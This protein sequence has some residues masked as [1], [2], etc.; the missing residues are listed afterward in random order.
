MILAHL[1][2]VALAASSVG[3]A[4]PIKPPV[5][6]HDAVVQPADPK[7]VQSVRLSLVLQNR[8]GLDSLLAQQ[9]DPNSP[10]FR[11]W[12][13]PTEIGERFGVPKATYSA[14]VKLLTDSGLRVKTFPNRIYIEAEG[15]VAKVN[16]LLG[17]NSVEVTV[18]SQHF[19]SFRGTP[20]LPEAFAALVQAVGGLDNRIRAKHRLSAQG[21]N[22]FGPQDLRRFYD[23]DALHAL[24]FG[25]QLSKV[26]M[27]GSVPDVNN[28]VNPAEINYFYQ[29]VSDSTATLVVD[30]LPLGS[31]Q[32]DSQPGLNIEEA[33]DA[34]MPTVAAP[35]VQ[36]V[37]MVLAPPDTLFTSGINEINNNMPDTTSVSISFGTCEAIEK[38]PNYT[39]NIGEIAAV[40]NL[41]AEGAAEG[42][43]YFSASG[44]YGVLTCLPDAQFAQ[45]DPTLLG[46]ANSPSV[47]FPSGVPY[48]TAVGGTMY[49]GTFDANNAIAAYGNETTW[50]EGNQAAGGGGVSVIFNKPPWQYGVPGTAV[51]GGMREV[52]DMAL[53]AD[54]SPGVAIVAT[55]VGQIDPQGNGTSDAA[56]MAA[57]MFAL[58]NDVIGGCRFG[59]VNPNL[60]ALAAAQYHGGASVLHDITTG[61]ISELNSTQQVVPGPM[62]QVGYDEATGVG[63]LDVT[64]LAQAWPS[65]LVGT[66][67]GGGITTFDGGYV[68]DGGVVAWDGG[69]GLDAG[70]RVPYDPCAL[71]TCDADAGATCV[72]VTE[73]PASCQIPCNPSVAN[74]C[75]AGN[76]CAGTGTNGTCQVGCGVTSDCTNNQVCDGCTHA[77]VAA[78]N[79]GA[80]IGDACNADTDCQTGGM[81][82]P[83]IYGLPGGYCSAQCSSSAVCSCPSGA[84]CLSLGGFAFCAEDCSVNGQD[85]RREASGYV[86]QPIDPTD[87]G[88]CFPACNNDQACFFD[89]VR[90]HCDP[91]LHYCVA[92]STTTSTSTSTGTTTS[93]TSTSTTSTSNSTGTSGT[94]STTSTNGTG[95]N[96]SPTA[97]TGSAGTNGT[98][99]PSTSTS[100]GSV[101]STS[102]SSGTSTGTTASPTTGSA[103]G[104]TGSTGTTNPKKGCGCGTGAGF[105]VNGALLLVLAAWT[106]RR[107]RLV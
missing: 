71:I 61:N 100:T 68:W 48:M 75:G 59:G 27:I 81:C 44:D 7:S 66:P 37:T 23:I 24:G 70:A 39:A 105:E 6:P 29:A 35:L 106:S 8:N 101:N 78:G 52:P 95:T 62:A 10:M 89:P 22:T 60:Y 2:S 74:T 58:I 41:V 49:T 50:N 91:T 15:T 57:G 73:G 14:M 30:Q 4:L 69:F 26:A 40:E 46:Y 3:R 43:S 107:R 18:G 72:T 11:H 64:A 34:E 19:R 96:G 33:M 9:R 93:T 80:Q 12:L 82:L 21:Q 92:P 84:S 102:S 53:L 25:G 54:V 79:T 76:Y 86:C 45:G 65:C 98:T 55:Q 36:S 88:V 56:P 5:F 51:D 83:A 90:T 1:L 85:C 67:T 32:P 38:D 16:A 28:A 47:D 103:A 97:S 87:N 13:T 104:S 17:I 94:T 20:R 99:G 63:S 77:C 31:S 42:I